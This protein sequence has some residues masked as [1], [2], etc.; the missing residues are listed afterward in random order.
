MQKTSVTIITEK[1]SA[2][3]KNKTILHTLSIICDVV[4]VSNK[5]NKNLSVISSKSL[6]EWIGILPFLFCKKL[7]MEK[8][9]F[10][11]LKLHTSTS[12]LKLKKMV[13]YLTL[14]PLCKGISICLLSSVLYIRAAQVLANFIDANKRIKGVQI[15]DHEIKLVNFTDDITIFSEDITC[16]NRIQVILKL[17]E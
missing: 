1:K 14:L 7:D 16:L 3:V 5:L 17:Y 12:S 8:N 13:S 6:V 11:R 9:S 2:A 10:V 4:D 15:G